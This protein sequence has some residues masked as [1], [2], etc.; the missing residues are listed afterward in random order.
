MP[1][2][3]EDSEV[4]GKELKHVYV[5][6]SAVC[7]RNGNYSRKVREK[8]LLQLERTVEQEPQDQKKRITSGK[9]TTL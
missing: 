7:S 6:Q 4:E 9:S 8:T 2:T 1:A 5:L 3:G